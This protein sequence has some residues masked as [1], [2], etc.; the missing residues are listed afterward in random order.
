MYQFVSLR[1]TLHLKIYTNTLKVGQ[2]CL[3]DQ[4]CNSSK[5]VHVTMK[6]CRAKTGKKRN[7][8]VNDLS[9]SSQVRYKV[10][11]RLN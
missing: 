3:F 9:R 7:A 6:N 10:A 8:E 5:H 4:T 2:A 1:C 11:P